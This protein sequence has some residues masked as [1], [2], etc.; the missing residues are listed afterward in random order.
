MP[1]IN[2]LSE[3]EVNGVYFDL[4]ELKELEE[5]YNKKN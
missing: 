1:T 2:V 4:K 5:E 3:M